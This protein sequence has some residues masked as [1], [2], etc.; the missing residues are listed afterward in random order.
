MDTPMWKPN[1]L[2]TKMIIKE[3][4]YLTSMLAVQKYTNKKLLLS[5]SSVEQQFYH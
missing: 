3:R 1:M 5:P 4:Y 2:S